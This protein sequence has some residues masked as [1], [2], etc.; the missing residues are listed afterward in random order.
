MTVFGLQASWEFASDFKARGSRA[1][2]DGMKKLS[3]SAMPHIFD[4][5]NFAQVAEWEAKYL[6]ADS[7]KKYDDSFGPYDPRARGAATAK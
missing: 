3:D 5:V 2:V 1:V 7:L 6:P 4:L